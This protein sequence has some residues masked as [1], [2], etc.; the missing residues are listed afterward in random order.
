MDAGD[1]EARRAWLAFLRVPGL[2]PA[3]GGRLLQLYPDPAALF[4]AGARSWRA[5][6]LPDAVC[7][8]LAGADFA[9]ADGDLRW[10]EQPGRHFLTR[11][12]P[13]FPAALR[14]I[15]AAPLG[16]FAVGDPA[17]LAAPQLAIV[18][19]RHATAQGIDNA[20]DFAVELARAGLTVTSGLALGIDTAAHRGALDAGA[21]TIAVCGNGLDRVYP[22]RNRDL[23]HRIAEHGLL[24][25]E[26]APGTAPRPENFP[27][28]NRIISGLSLGVLVV[29]AARESGSLITARLA[30]EQG[31]EVF[32]I[33]GSI[34]NPLS[35]GCHRLI[36]DGARLVESVADILEELEPQLAAA[37]QQRSAATGSEYGGESGGDRGG[38]WG[39]NWGG[40]PCAD[41]GMGGEPDDPAEPT[42]PEEGLLLQALGDEPVSFDLLVRRTGLDAARLN[43]KLLE[44]ELVGK[45]APMGGDRFMRRRQRH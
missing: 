27:R 35:R 15:G 21:A 43:A 7:E 17:L 6:G 8:S 31:R 34:H 14:E 13:A 12:D 2:G 18:G 44:L 32:A 30:A 39:G 5:H 36:R 45:I 11:D 29:E 28:R 40:K 37:S 19:A 16:L 33:P 20:H 26:F 25:S 3:L 41:T 4:A 10:L 9:A 38:D 22:A 23:A 42:T 24:L 1:T